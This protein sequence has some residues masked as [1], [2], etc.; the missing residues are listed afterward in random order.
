[1]L[2]LDL[3]RVSLEVQIL[4]DETD[5]AERRADEAERKT[6]VRP[7]RLHVCVCVCVCV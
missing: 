5:E 6:K 4:A 3:E 2:K 7:A 1:M